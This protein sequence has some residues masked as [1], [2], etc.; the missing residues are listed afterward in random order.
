MKHLEHCAAVGALLAVAACGSGA[1]N[2][3]APANEA[4]AT[5]PPASDSMAAENATVTS[6]DGQN[7]SVNRTGGIRRTG[8]ETNYTL[9]LPTDILFDFDKATLR[10]E[11]EPMMR[12]VLADLEG[13]SVLALQVFGHTDAKGDEAYNMKL[14]LR[15]AG[16]VCDYL[17]KAG[18]QYTLCLG[19]GEQEPV[20]P[21]ANPDGSDNPN[22][23]QMNRRVEIKVALRPDVDAMMRKAK[24]QSRGAKGTLGR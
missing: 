24:D 15:R 23:R 3:A 22:G 12:D 5:R 11:A 9:N 19:R 16:A 6:S 4:N 14:S 7:F 8:T 18:K 17:K 1:R 2:E 13:K 21:N 20:A 10:P